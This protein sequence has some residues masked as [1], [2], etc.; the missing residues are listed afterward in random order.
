M[1]FIVHE[2]KFA[3]QSETKKMKVGKT[4]VGLSTCRWL[5][6]DPA[7]QSSQL[8][9]ND[10]YNVQHSIQDDPTAT[11]RKQY[12]LNNHARSDTARACDLRSRS[13]YECM[14]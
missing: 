2:N 14:H 9:Y 8:T 13:I 4:S 12:K 6:V 5:N 10:P 7:L 3:R 1:L 11:N